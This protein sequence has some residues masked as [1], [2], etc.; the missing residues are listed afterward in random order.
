MCQIVYNSLMIVY[1]PVHLFVGLH[2]RESESDI[3]SH[4]T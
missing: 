4:D 2:T 3:V 1:H